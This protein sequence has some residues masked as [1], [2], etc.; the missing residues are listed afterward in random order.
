MAGISLE[1]SALA[2]LAHDLFAILVDLLHRLRR[3]REIDFADLI[4]FRALG[5]LQAIH[6]G[7]NFLFGNVDEGLDLAA[8]QP[9]PGHFAFDLALD[10]LVRRALCGEILGEILGRVAEISRHAGE[11]L[12]Q[13][14]L[15][16][17]DILGSCRLNLQRLV[18]EIAQNLQL[19][20]VA[21]L[22]A[23]LAAIGEHDQR[24][25]LIDVRFGD[26]LAVHQRGRL[27]DI[28]IALAEECEGIRD[29][30]RGRR[31]VGIFIAPRLRRRGL[32][33]QA[34]GSTR[35]HQGRN[36]R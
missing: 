7:A 20:P 11:V 12:V 17:L 25:A 32:D 4:F 15:R 31:R 18:D 10:A 22:V 35:K 6:H 9:V 33:H 23:H 14:R 5:R 29:V 8:Q 36:P 24:Q 27:A 26:H 2:D 19:E 28:G 30:E 1:R 3:G 21:F 13:L 34:G 16:D